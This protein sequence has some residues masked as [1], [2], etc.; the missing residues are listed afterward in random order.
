MGKVEGG[1]GQEGRE[2]GRRE[3]KA[4]VA[5]EGQKEEEEEQAEKG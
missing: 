3:G 4:D 5:G 2:R 1:R